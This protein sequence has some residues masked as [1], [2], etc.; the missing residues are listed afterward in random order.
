[1]YEFAV[2]PGKQERTP[3]PSAAESGQQTLFPA[4]APRVVAFD[5]LTSPATRDAIR[6][7]AAELS[8]P[9]PLRT[10]KVEVSPRRARESSPKK[11]KRDEQ[12]RFDFRGQPETVSQPQSSIECDAPVAPISMR[13]HAAFV[14]VAIMATGCLIAVFTFRF[15]GGIIAFDRHSAPFVAAALAMIPVFYKLLWSFADRDT[16]GMRV[17][18]LKLVD[19]DGNPPPRERR[20]SRTLGSFISLLAAGIG[21]VWILV[22]E[23]G[24]SW[25]DHMSSTFPTMA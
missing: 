17:A 22:D 3:Q 23:D 18:G 19:L 7:R 21:L 5:S 20:Y 24:L 11:R 10:G 13:V 6:E 16:I 4:A 8:R 15:C 1:M 12:Q 2:E 14:D 9:A 25:H